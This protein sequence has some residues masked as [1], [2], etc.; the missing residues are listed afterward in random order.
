MTLKPCPFPG[1]FR[2][3]KFNDKCYE[4]YDAAGKPEDEETGH[5]FYGGPKAQAEYVCYALNLAAGQSVSEEL[6]EARELVERLDTMLVCCWNELNTKAKWSAE[7]EEE[8]SQ[9]I[10]R[11]RAR[12]K[13]LLGG[14][15]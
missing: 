15:D 12:A 1:P 14:G 6:Q 5:Y 2:V 10:D 11:V 3:V 13:K 7:Q 9:E 8:I 4:V